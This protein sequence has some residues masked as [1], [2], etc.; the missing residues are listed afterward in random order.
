MWPVLTAF[1][2][3]VADFITGDRTPQKYANILT[4]GVFTFMIWLLVRWHV[5]S[6]FIIRDSVVL[7]LALLFLTFIFLGIF[8]EL[9]N[10][11]ELFYEAVISMSIFFFAIYVVSIIHHTGA[12]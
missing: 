11:H 3:H 1:F 6:S 7:S 5:R 9:P 10:P 2:M 12:K 4:F 8:Q